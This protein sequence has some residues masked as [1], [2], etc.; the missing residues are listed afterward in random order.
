MFAP[1]CGTVEDVIARLMPLVHGAVGLMTHIGI[2]A[3][4]P[5]TRTE[6]AERT[7]TLFAREVMP[8][9]KAETAKRKV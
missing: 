9:L 8:V 3:R 6:D 1:I 5:G 7:M 4:P 2:E